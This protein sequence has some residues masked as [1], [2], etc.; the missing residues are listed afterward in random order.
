MGRKPGALSVT[1]AVRITRRARTF[2]DL[3]GDEINNGLCAAFARR[4]ARRTTEDVRIVG[5]PRI[6]PRMEIEA[7][8][9]EMEGCGHVWIFDGEKHFD[10][11]MEEGTK[12]PSGLP[13]LR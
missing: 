6:D 13:A 4:V 9:D 2:E 10:A 1:E 7:M 11:E 12:D 3:S 5:D 8:T